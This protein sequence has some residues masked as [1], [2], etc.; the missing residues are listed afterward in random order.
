MNIISVCVLGIFTVLAA[1]VIRKYNGEISL[2]L[3]ITAIIFICVAV[4]PT[5][6]H[7]FESIKDLTNSANI[8]NEY[9][10]T[11]LKSLG[12]CYV[13]Q[14]SA[15]ICRENGSGSIASQIEIS[16]KILILLTAIPLYS[17]LI[18]MIYNF[19]V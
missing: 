5:L 2:L 10:S 7:V 8:K 17:D 16:G 11:L 19:L 1:T 14:I 4:V 18:A 15:D 9:V 13:T 12:I 6:S 3:T